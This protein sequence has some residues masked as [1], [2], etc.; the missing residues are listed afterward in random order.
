MY[1]NIAHLN[2]ITTDADLGLQ[3]QEEYNLEDDL[4]LFTNTQFFDFVDMGDVPDDSKPFSPTSA[5]SSNLQSAVLQ[6]D[7]QSIDFLIGELDEPHRMLWH[8]ATY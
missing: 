2:A 5:L 8:I 7:S 1:P 3:Q 4:D 6:S